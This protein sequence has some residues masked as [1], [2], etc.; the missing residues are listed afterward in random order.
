MDR[1]R[2]LLTSLA[3]ALAAPLGAGAQH[4][5]TIPRIGVLDPGSRQM[6]SPCL[7]AFQQGLRDLGYVEGRN[8]AVE[9]RYAEGHPDRLPGLANELVRFAP[10]LIWIHSTPTALVAKHRISTIPVV[11]GVATDLVELGIVASLARPGGNLTGFELR[12]L[13]LLGKQLELLKE[14][15]P[16]IVRLAVL[17]DPTRP[18]HAR[19]TRK[20]EDQARAIGVQLIGVEAG[21]PEAFEAAFATMRRVGSNGL[22]IMDAALFATHREQILALA[23]QHRLPTI[24]G[25]GFFARE[26][27]L[28]AYGADVRDLCRRSAIYADRILKGAKP[29]DLPV[30]QPTKFE[31]VINLK[32]AKALGLTIPPSL[33]ARADQVIE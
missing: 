30:E 9:Y 32:T 19:V 2:F 1:R 5:R 22:M 24:S 18:D 31:F 21:S 7:P 14:A 23:V 27:G 26:G 25:A 33:L 8:I 20:L 12:T 16:R 15:V 6:L 10:D 11:I 3:G 4:Q 28:L 29:G 13:E 17:I